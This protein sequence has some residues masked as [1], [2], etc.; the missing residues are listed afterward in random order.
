[1]ATF[2]LKKNRGVE[3]A[4]ELISKPIKVAILFHLHTVTKVVRVEP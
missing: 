3:K 2:Q 1:V 4:A